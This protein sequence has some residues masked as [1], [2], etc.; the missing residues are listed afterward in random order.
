MNRSH[1]LKNNSVKPVDVGISQETSGFD[2]DAGTS[3]PLDELRSI[4]V[5]PEQRELQELRHRLDDPLIRAE[6][7]SQSLP[8]AFALS[9]AR[10]DKIARALQ[11]TIDAT[12]KAS[13]RKNP[14]ALADAL[15]P[16]LGP[17]I[18][19]AITATIRGM[20][21][22]L[23]HVLNQSCSIQGIKWRFEA[24]R[25]HKTFAEIVLLHTLVF[26]VDRVFTIHPETGVVL[27]HAHSMTA[28][29][30]DPD[31]V[32]GMLTAIQDFVKDSFQST[33]DSDLDALRV[34]PDQSVWIDRGPHV[35]LAAV[36]QGTPPMSL[37]D[38][39]REALTDFNEKFGRTLE[40]FDGDTGVFELYKDTLE[41][42]L[43][44]K[45][46]EKKRSVSPFLLLIPA[47]LLILIGINAVY[48]YQQHQRWNEYLDKLTSEPGIVVTN[49]RKVDDRYVVTGLKDPLAKDP[50]SLMN[51]TG[52][53][54]DEV[55]FR[56]Q[57]YYAL[58]SA[59]VLSRAKLILHPPESVQISMK[60]NVLTAE[61]RADHQWIL[62]FRATA[63]SIPG[64]T[65]INDG[66]L[67]DQDLI[68]LTQ[69][70]E[71]L[72]K[73]NIYF[74]LAESSF[75]EGQEKTLTEVLDTIKEI[76]KVQKTLHYQVS[77]IITGHTD[78]TGTAQFNL[79]LSR[80]RA[81][82]ILLY[83][84]GHHVDTRHITTIG[85]GGKAI[86]TNSVQTDAEPLHRVVTFKTE[87]ILTGES[88]RR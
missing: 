34:G 17:G 3:G 77:I 42:C 31:L 66:K 80:E 13:V 75:Q 60:N 9:T 83:L 32:S 51:A 57:P 50:I 81:K 58:N 64:I 47:L 38:V 30:Q 37:R 23:N 27:L 68:K 67:V 5:E 79:R 2:T 26:R 78:T 14:K 46:R 52:L 7:L 40:N 82:Q 44:Y 22:S 55:Y 21:Q 53:T 54:P 70:R 72:E 62:T 4:L 10:T 12:I 73:F 87:L 19:K 49:A 35:Y 88:D 76:Q 1:S 11:P 36:I 74:P 24:Y 48:S 20:I 39:F 84:A 16:V 86:D 6:E 45:E 18:R 41:D 59:I 69:L 65:G 15:F 71:R 8:D 25:T 85:A 28:T 43:V 33:S 63:P 61:G 56:W 29:V